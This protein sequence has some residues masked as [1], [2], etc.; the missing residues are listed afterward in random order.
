MTDTIPI[1]VEAVNLL[2]DGL[3]SQI[4]IAAQQITDADG[5][6]GTREHPERYTD[7][8]HRIDALR[9]VMDEIGWHKTKPQDYLQLDLQV[10]GWALTIALADEIGTHVDLLRDN[11]QD[12]ER[13]RAI[14]GSINTLTALALAVLLRTQAHILR[15]AKLRGPRAEEAYAGPFW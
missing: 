3:R 8:L 12:A 2:R 10:H 11:E 13:Y 4:A 5:E 14:R 9:A 7:P 6:L 1:P 15:A